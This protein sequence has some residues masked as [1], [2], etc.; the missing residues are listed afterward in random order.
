MESVSFERVVEQYYGPLY[1]FA[2]SLTRTEADACDLTQQTFYVWA[3]KS[4]Q[5]RDPKSAKTWLFTTLHRV[6]LQ[7]RR[8]ETRFPHEPLNETDDQ[9]PFTCPVM[10]SELDWEQMLEALGRVDENYQAAVA[11]F[12]LEECSYGEIAQVLEIPVGTVKSRLSRGLG[13]LKKILI[14]TS[15][16]G[17]IGKSQHE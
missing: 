2:Y 17:H 13:Q 9:L 10:A 1:K 6:F 4:H 11:L 14:E 12:Y 15:A 3:T 8:R 16:P 7:S 5:L